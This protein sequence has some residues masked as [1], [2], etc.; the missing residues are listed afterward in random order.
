[1]KV[2]KEATADCPAELKDELRLGEM[3]LHPERY[4]NIELLHRGRNIVLL[5][6]DSTTGQKYVVKGFKKPNIVQRIAYT[7]FTPGKARRAF[8]YAAIMRQ[9]GISTPREVAYIEVY[10]HGLLSHSYFVSEYC[11]WPSLA[12][13]WLPIKP[14][15]DNQLE[16]VARMMAD[17]HKAG[18]LHGDTN[19]GNFL[20]SAPSSITTVDVNRTRF[21]DH[22]PTRKECLDNMVKLTH[23][24]EVIYKITEHY[25][26]IRGWDK[27]ESAQYVLDNLIEYEK[28]RNRRNKLK[29][30]AR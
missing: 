22:E 14:Y 20:Y 26:D 17:M 8:D 7:W 6:T 5:Y 30:L 11:P 10:E 21:L 3:C 16:T 1:M 2:K 12:S 15:D 28:K 19:I 25:A 9:R 24:R 18:V 27:R 23:R 29:H 4:G 13:L